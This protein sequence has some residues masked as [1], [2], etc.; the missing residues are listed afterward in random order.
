MLVCEPLERAGFT[1]AFSTRLGGVSSLP[2]AALS[3]GNFRQDS[4][5]NILEN[6]R[7]FQTAL[8]VTEWTLTTANQI[9]SAD[10]R[11]VRDAQDAQAAPTACDALTANLPRTLLAVQ[12]ADC[13]PIL[14]IDERTRAFAA[15]HAGWR[16]TL[17]CIVARTLERMQ[18]SFDTRPDDVKAAFGPAI[19]ACCFEVGPEVIEQFEREFPN[20]A[21]AVSKRQANGKAYLN[22]S[23]INR[24]ILLASGVAADKVFDCGLCTSCHTELF[25]SYRREHGADQPIG[26]LMGVVG[27]VV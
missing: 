12:I 15:I 14:L 5:E 21:A 9:H 22:L 18:L 6:R 26:R 8:A 16:G 2:S 23:R 25:F 4:R 11:S 3:L 1:N 13:M 10:V 17:A 19:G 24:Q 7:R 27:R 20:A